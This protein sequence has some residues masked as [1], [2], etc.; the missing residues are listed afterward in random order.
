VK[1]DYGDR[2]D[3]KTFKARSLSNAG[4]RPKLIACH[5]NRIQDEDKFE[6]YLTRSGFVALLSNGVEIDDFE[7]LVRS[8]TYYLSSARSCELFRGLEI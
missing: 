5:L 4:Q 2:V 3:Q 6:N 8:V 1:I 7:D